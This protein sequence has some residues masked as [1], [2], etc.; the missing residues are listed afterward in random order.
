VLRTRSPLGLLWSCDQMDP[1]RLACVKHA[2]SVRPEPGSNSPSRTGPGKPGTIMFRAHSPR[3]L[4]R[5]SIPGLHPAAGWEARR[6]RVA[7]DLAAGSR[8]DKQCTIPTRGSGRRTARTGVLSSLPFSRSRSSWHVP[9]EGSVPF[10]ADQGRSARRM[11]TLAARP[12]ARQPWSGEN[13]DE[14]VR[15]LAA[16]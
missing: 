1:V 5:D 12:R 3:A 15:L 4:C 10:P 8:I 9:N 11:C 16:P 2:A 14:V 13:V 7:T 6:I